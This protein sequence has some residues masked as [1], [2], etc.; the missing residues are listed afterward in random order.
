MYPMQVVSSTSREL[1]KGFTKDLDDLSARLGAT[2][3]GRAE[4]IDLSKFESLKCCYP[5]VP[6]L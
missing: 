5:D 1:L 3:F 6:R 4:D 2:S